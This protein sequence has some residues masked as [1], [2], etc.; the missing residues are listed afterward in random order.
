MIP[1]EFKVEILDD[2]HEIKIPIFG[3]ELPPDRCSTYA[4]LAAELIFGIHYPEIGTK[5][6]RFE[7]EIETVQVSNSQLPELVGRGTVRPGMLLGVYSARNRYND[8]I[9]P[10]AHLALF[11]GQQA[12]VP[13]FLE[14][15]GKRIR[16]P[17]LMDYDLEGFEIKE[18]LFL[19]N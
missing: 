8:G 7:H 4:R 1:L 19:R 2:S 16:T 5:Q 14:Q 6:M 15:L 11:L 3:P 13:L 10:Y 18:A 9:H 12:R 17:N